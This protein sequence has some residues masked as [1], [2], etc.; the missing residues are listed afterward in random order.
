M[1]IIKDQPPLYLYSPKSLPRSSK[2]T[3]NTTL[4]K[5]CAS[6]AFIFRPLSISTV[7]TSFSR[8]LSNIAQSEILAVYTLHNVLSFQEYRGWTTSASESRLA[9]QACSK[10]HPQLD[11][12]SKLAAECQSLRTSLVNEGLSGPLSQGSVSG[13]CVVD[14]SYLHVPHVLFLATRREFAKSFQRQTITSVV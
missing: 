3:L 2:L 7:V 4:N 12:R 6:Q 5:D 1:P 13:N 14:A 11:Q 9:C 8:R 10:S